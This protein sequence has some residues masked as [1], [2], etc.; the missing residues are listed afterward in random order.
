MDVNRPVWVVGHKNPD[1]DSICAAITYAALK[2]KSEEGTFIPKKAGELNGETRY[3]LDYF[4]VEAPE[5]VESAGTQLKDLDLRHTEGIDGNCTMKKVWELMKELD[6]ATLPI[7]DDSNYLEGLVVNGDIAYSYMDVYDNAV[8][9]RAKTQYKN[10]AETLDGKVESGNEHAYFTKGKIV[11]PAGDRHTMKDIIETDDLVILGDIVLR[12]EIAIDLGASCIVVCTDG[13]VA[14]DILDMAAEHDC[15]VISTKYDV[16][17]AAR[18]IH[19]SMAVKYFMKKDNLVTFELDDY[20]DYVKDVISKVRH[21]DFPV[22]DGERH[23]TAMFSRRN[24]M[25]AQKKQI[26]LVDHNEKSQTIDH[27]EEAE[28]LEI[29]DHHRLGSL[30]TLS[31]IYFRNQPLGCTASIIYSMYQEKGVEIDRTTAGLLCAAILSDTL[32]FRSPTCTPV[33]E[34]I[35]RQLARIAGI[36]IESF[37]VAMFEAGSDFKDKTP[38]EI[39]TTDFKTFRFEGMK[40]GVA[41]VSAVSDKQLKALSADISDCMDRIMVDKNLDMLFVMMTNVIKEK[42]VLLSAGSEA[43]EV[44]QI[45]FSDKEK[46]EYGVLLPGVVSRKK[47]LVPTLMTAL[48][49]L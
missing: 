45:A 4:G 35:G 14:D 34:E 29:I 17:T 37:A 26:I 27:I 33:D 44:M 18:L 10:I 8:L 43:A 41:Q 39:A 32:M 1:T 28:I 40:L 23:Y 49:E 24:L 12:Q 3:V 13:Y 7:V 25:N 11:I 20:V 36:D 16:F 19:Q 21:R 6:V 30:E 15:V 22:L 31:P 5:T 46:T 47:Q 48:Q 9:S 2:N 38:E 42:T